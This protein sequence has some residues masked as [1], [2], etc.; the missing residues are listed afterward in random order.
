[1][2]N[3]S[4]TVVAIERLAKQIPHVIQI[5]DVPK[6]V[7]EWRALQAEEETAEAL[8][9]VDHFWRGMFDIKHHDRSVKYTIVPHVIMP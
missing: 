2:I 3:K 9:R 5:E 8:I 7:D 1:M 4:Y 6:A